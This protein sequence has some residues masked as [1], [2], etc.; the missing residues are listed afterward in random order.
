LFDLLEV[1][2]PLAVRERVES[3]DAKGWGLVVRHAAAVIV[4]LIRIQW[5]SSTAN[6]T[7]CGV[8]DLHGRFRSRCKQRGYGSGHPRPVH[9]KRQARGS[10]PW[11][12]TLLDP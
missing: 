8:G 10:F 6:L 4:G 11:T 5:S 1:E 7:P 3:H 2:E 9:L 12:T